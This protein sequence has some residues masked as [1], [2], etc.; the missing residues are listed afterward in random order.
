MS[1]CSELLL[2]FEEPRPR[3][4]A[5]RKR[6]PDLDR[7]IL[8]AARALTGELGVRGASVSAISARAGVGKPSLYLRWPDK[9]QI[10]LAAIADLRCEVES[11]SGTSLAGAL[12]EAL[13]DDYKAL[14]FGPDRAFLRAVLQESAFSHEIAAALQDVILA[15]RYKRIRAIL[16][17][18]RRTRTATDHHHA[19]AMADLLHGQ[20]IRDLVAGNRDRP[21]PVEALEGLVLGVG[22]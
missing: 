22:F 19:V 8:L 14:V 13:S 2:N 7:R 20:L 5:G 10:V 21:P 12:A 3:S 6:D 4:R 17:A 15:P 1:I 16:S 9:T 11:V 18:D